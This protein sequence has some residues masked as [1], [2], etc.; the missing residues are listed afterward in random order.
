MTGSFPVTKQLLQVRLWYNDPVTK[1]QG[2]GE[3]WSEK[4]VSTKVSYILSPWKQVLR[5]GV[6]ALNR[7]FSKEDV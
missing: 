5:T 3:I 4:G 1:K 2:R 6:P 7:Q